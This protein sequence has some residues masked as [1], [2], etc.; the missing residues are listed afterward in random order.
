MYI[1]RGFKME[2]DNWSKFSTPLVKIGN[3]LSIRVPMNIAKEQKVKNG[4]AIAVKIKKIDYE[5]TKKVLDIYVNKALKLKELKKYSKEKLYLF[6]RILFNE[7]KEALKVTNNKVNAKNLKKERIKESKKYLEKI[8]KEFGEKT[9]REYEK[10][11]TQLSKN[12]R[13]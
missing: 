1:Q 2:K 4:E 12:I 3:S 8:K 7:G 5:P 11:K 13:N 9:Y 6:S 10:F